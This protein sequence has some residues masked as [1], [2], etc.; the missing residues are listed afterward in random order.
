M[1]KAGP[2]G[3]AF[4]SVKIVPNRQNASVAVW[5]FVSWEE[6]FEKGEFGTFLEKKACFARHFDFLR[7]PNAE[8]LQSGS[9]F[10]CWSDPG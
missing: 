7:K 5:D 10:R 2:G 6:I 1:Q 3:P 8:P 9:V 4:Q